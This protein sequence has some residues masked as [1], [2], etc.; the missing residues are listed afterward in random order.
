MEL[1]ADR[2]VD[3]GKASDLVMVPLEPAISV[4]YVFAYREPGRI[5]SNFIDFVDRNR[6]FLSKTLGNVRF[7][8]PCRTCPRIQQRYVFGQ[9]YAR[10]VFGILLL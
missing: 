8:A 7:L 4:R 9:V 3:M 5:E 6:S 10:A 2:E 1:Y